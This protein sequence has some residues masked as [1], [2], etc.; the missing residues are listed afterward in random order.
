MNRRSSSKISLFLMELIIA[1]MFFSLASAVCVR[2]FSS[3]HI[4]SEDSINLNNA[5]TWSQNLSEAFYGSKGQLKELEKLYPQAFISTDESDADKNT[6]I[7]FF[8]E[9]WDL[10]AEGLTDASFEAILETDRQPADTVYADVNQYGVTLSGDAV[11]GKVAVIDLRGT[12]EVFSSIPA[13]SDRIIY[14][15]NVDVYVGKE[16]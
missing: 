8:D 7:L 6:I 4:M 15:G 3:A 12:T 2:L 11:V 9:K 1:I 10:N 14:A 16:E 5:V 13:G